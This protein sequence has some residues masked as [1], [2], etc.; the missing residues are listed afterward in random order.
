MS[1]AAKKVEIKKFSLDCSVPAEDEI[2]D[3]AH[4]EEFLKTRVKVDGKTGNLTDRVVIKRDGNKLLVD[5]QTPFS[6]R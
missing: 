4:F 1:K 6:K 3:V 2:L 5:A